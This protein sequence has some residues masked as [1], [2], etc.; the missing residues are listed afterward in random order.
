MRG[1]SLNPDQYAA[2]SLASAPLSA[3]FTYGKRYKLDQILIKFNQNVYETVTVT[4]ISKNGVNYNEVL[5]T[6]TLGGESS[7]S[8]RP[9]G[10]ANF[11][12]LDSIQVKCTNANGIGI[13]YVTCKTSQLGSG[14]VN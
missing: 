6:Q 14:Q 2:Q 12:A 4:L 13:A 11:P 5:D 3:T 10:E 7:Y 1:I 8:F 9:T